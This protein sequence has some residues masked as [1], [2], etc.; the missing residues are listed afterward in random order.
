MWNKIRWHLQMLIMLLSEFGK[1]YHDIYNLKWA[2][3]KRN[4]KLD[5]KLA[6]STI[7]LFSLW[8]YHSS[9]HRHDNS[10]YTNWILFPFSICS[11][12]LLNLYSHDFNKTDFAKGVTLTKSQK[13][14]KCDMSVSQKNSSNDCKSSNSVFPFPVRHKLNRYI[15]RKVE[16]K[17]NR[18]NEMS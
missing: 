13:E 2:T 8:S 7:L 10:D 9:Y 15:N 14:R 1:K 4:E 12:I 18:Q 16:R 5:P 11:Q 3:F 6:M 17:K